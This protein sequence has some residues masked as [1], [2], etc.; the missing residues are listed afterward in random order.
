[1]VDDS[2]GADRCSGEAVGVSWAEEERAIL[3]DGA[4]SEEE[5]EGGLSSGLPRRYVVVDPSPTPQAMFDLH[6]SIQLVKLVATE[7]VMDSWLWVSA[8]LQSLQQKPCPWNLWQIFFPLVLEGMRSRCFPAKLLFQFSPSCSL[9]LL[10]RWALMTLVRLS[11]LLCRLHLDPSSFLLLSFLSSSPGRL[12][13]CC[14]KQGGSAW[15][16][17]PRATSEKSVRKSIGLAEMCCLS[18]L[19]MQDCKYR[20]TDLS[21]RYWNWA[22]KDGSIAKHVVYCG[23]CSVMLFHTQAVAV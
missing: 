10:R 4:S 13:P 2:F 17:V 20:Y 18:S 21:M 8:F 1:V 23:R 14:L 11:L 12:R 15:L 22:G 7:G 9:C 16:N 5:V 6:F 3:S 19:C